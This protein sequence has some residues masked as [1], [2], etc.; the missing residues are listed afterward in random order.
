MKT[1]PQCDSG[2]PDSQMVCPSHGG[3]L[4]EIRDLK[5]GMLIRNTYR[6]V[7]KLGQG[8][9]GAVYLARHTLMDEPMALKFLSSELSRDE[10]FTNRFLREVRTLRQVRHKNVVDAGNLEPAEDGTLFFPMEFVDG[11]DL[12]KLMDA[13]PKPFDVGLALSIARGIAEGLGAAHAKGMVHRDIKPENILMARDGE[14][15]IPKIADFG[16]VATRELSQYTQTGSLLLTPFYAAPEQWM[17]MRA[18]ELDGRTDLYALGGVLFEMLTGQKAFSAENYQGWAH[19]HLTTMPQPPSSLRPDLA[20]WKGLDA[21]VLHLLAKERDQ[22]P[23]DVAET[24]HLLDAVVYVP[25]PVVRPVT[26]AESAGTV[27]HGGAGGIAG[28]VPVWVWA[29]A[30]AVL[31]IAAFVAGRIFSPRA[32]IPSQSASELAPPTSQA[33]PAGPGSAQDVR[34]NSSSPNPSASRTPA[35]AMVV[36]SKPPAQKPQPGSEPNAPTEGASTPVQQASVADVELQAF[37]LF[38]RKR[39]SAARPLFQKACDGGDLGG[40][41]NLGILYQNGQGGAQDFAQARALYQKACDGGTT[42][43]CVGLGILF[44]NGQGGAQ[45]YAQA[46]SLYQ[47]ACDGGT[48]DGC[49]DIGVL[50]QN[51]QGGTQDYAQAAIL[52]QKACVGGSMDGCTGLGFLFDTGQGV[53]Q[54]HAQAR[55]WFQKACV[56]GNVHGCYDLGVLYEHGQGGAQDYAQARTLYQQACDGGEMEGCTGLGV[57]YA[58]AEGVTQDY[59]QARTWC[60]KACDGGN[61]S[62]CYDLG[63]F[64]QKG[65]GV[66]QDNAQARTWYQ[67]ACNGGNQ[68]ACTSLQSLP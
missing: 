3:V 19:E 58:N 43:G 45:D 8:G 49:F 59:A 33:L 46:R 21:L 6:I 24:L 12:R 62:G 47:K 13:A 51:G 67:K 41:S 52:Y 28:R 31:L 9:M 20:N 35:P 29:A 27:G 25:P 5:P 34:P 4:N 38:S 16:I 54:D 63:V 18:A 26:V 40:C 42:A 1:C 22:R 32:S 7:R 65:E 53:T 37:S 2:Y 64:Y 36:A 56:G 11:P 60:Q 48:M 15:W 10:G 57:L 30:L 23:K 55:L 66:T 14:N 50:Y 39:Y 61:M 68:D 44:Q 17:G